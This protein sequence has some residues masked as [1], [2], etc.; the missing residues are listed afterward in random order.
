MVGSVKQEIRIK[1]GWEL[2]MNCVC[3]KIFSQIGCLGLISP[4]NLLRQRESY[5]M[6]DKILNCQIQGGRFQKH[7]NIE[8]KLINIVLKCVL[9]HFNKVIYF[10]KHNSGYFLIYIAVYLGVR[11][12]LCRNTLECWQNTRSGTTLTIKYNLANPFNPKQN[13]NNQ[14]VSS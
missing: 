7:M 2:M 5:N 13:T 14:F 10:Y 4:T 6:G 8:M 3:I 1:S 9:F 11:R 12:T